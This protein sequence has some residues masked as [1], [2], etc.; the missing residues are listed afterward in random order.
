[1]MTNNYSA[2]Y[3]NIHDPP[4]IGPDLIAATRRR[5]LYLTFSSFSATKYNISYTPYLAF[6]TIPGFI[7]WGTFNSFIPMKDMEG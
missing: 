3:I 5:V 4:R 2:E 6:I 1:M 7:R